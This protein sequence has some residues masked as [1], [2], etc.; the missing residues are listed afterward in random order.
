MKRLSKFLAILLALGMVL[1]G[2][3]FGAQ[4]VH[5]APKAV[6]LEILTPPTKTH[7][8]AGEI[9]DTAGA[10]VKVHYDDGTTSGVLT[11]NAYGG[12]YLTPDM[13][14]VTLSREG[15]SAIQP[16]TVDPVTEIPKVDVFVPVPQA[17]KK[18]NM[19]L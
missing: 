3:P 7:Y 15:V 12:N 11:P 2:L 14:Y 1:G 4:N 17:G 18:P 16:I 10:K 5:A 6:S 9:F 8:Q 13:T 19:D